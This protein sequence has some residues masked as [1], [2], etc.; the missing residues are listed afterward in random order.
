MSKNK[1]GER[2]SSSSST[3]A[4]IDTKKPRT[5]SHSE[6]AAN[7]KLLLQNLVKENRE[8]FSKL[9]KEISCLRLDIKEELKEVKR[10][11]SEVKKSVQEAWSTID[12]MKEDIAPPKHFNWKKLISSEKNYMRQIRSYWKHA[13]NCGEKKREILSWKTAQERKI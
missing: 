5:M 7:L 12:D 10:I 13:N 6:D 3:E 1:R 9:H 2:N 8:N 4:A 11:T